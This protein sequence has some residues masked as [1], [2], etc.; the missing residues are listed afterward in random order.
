MKVFYQGKPVRRFMKID[1]T[2]DSPVINF[3]DL[4]GGYYTLLMTDVDADNYIH[5]LI[6]NIN[7][8]PGGQLL[9]NGD[10]TV[11]YLGPNP[12]AGSGIHHYV[13]RMMRQ[14]RIYHPS[15]RQRSRFQLEKFATQNGLQEVQQAK[16][17]VRS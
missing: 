14:S 8:N 13:F 4:P 12:P 6:A 5:L 3:D 16:F 9:Y 7:V 1:E 15:T 11:P 2:I 10:I 17:G